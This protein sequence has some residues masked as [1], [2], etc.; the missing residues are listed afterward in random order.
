MKLWIYQYKWWI[1]PPFWTQNKK[2]RITRDLNGNTI[3]KEKRK[4]KRRLEWKDD[5]KRLGWKQDKKG[6]TKRDLRQRN[7]RRKRPKRGLSTHRIKRKK[8]GQK[9]T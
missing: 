3:K 9:E 1:Y 7:K 4:Y 2:E 6:R 5:K 8:K